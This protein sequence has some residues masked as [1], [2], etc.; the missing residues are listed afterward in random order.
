[1][2][3][4]ELL[5]GH[6]LGDYILQDDWQAKYKAKSPAPP[7]PAT[8]YRPAV[9]FPPAPTDPDFLAKVEQW[10]DEQALAQVEA[11]AWDN[12][13]AAV[14]RYLDQWPVN[15][16]ACLLHCFLYAL[17]FL[18]VTAVTGLLPWWFYVGVG[19]LHFPVDYYKLAGRW[20][21]ASRHAEF[22]SPSHPMFPWSIVVTDNIIHLVVAWGLA[23]V[24]I[25]GF[26]STVIVALAGTTGWFGLMLL[27]HAATAEPNI[28]AGR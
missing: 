3:G 2:L 4:F 7:G 10:R 23:I 28:K 1:M 11:D 22:A 15:F 18:P 8:Y 14:N 9:P 13:T 16:G 17:A 19:V 6:L 20:M 12:A 24:A 26:S 27:A 5:L 21:R 25:G